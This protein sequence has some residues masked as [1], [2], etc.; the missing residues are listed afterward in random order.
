MRSAFEW[1]NATRREY[2]TGDLTVTGTASGDAYTL[3][4][5]ALEQEVRGVRLGITFAAI[6]EEDPAN[7]SGDPRVASRIWADLLDGE[8][9]SFF[10]D[11]ERTESVVVKPDLGHEFTFFRYDQGP[12]QHRTLKMKTKERLALSDPIFELFADT[13]AIR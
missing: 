7:A 2:L 5:G 9:L 4:P 1:P 13:L 10:P 12:R 11:A 8:E 3:L 6:F